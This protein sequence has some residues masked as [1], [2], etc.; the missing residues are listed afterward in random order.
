MEKKNIVVHKSL[1]Y[2]NEPYSVESMAVDEK[3][4]ILA[5]AR[6][7]EERKRESLLEFWNIIGKPI[8][9]LKTRKLG[10]GGVEALLWVNSYLI[11]SHLDGS[12]HLHQLH[13]TDN[14]RIQVCPSPLWSLAAVRDN[15]FCAGSDSGAIFFLSLSNGKITVEKT[16]NI[17]FGMR[18]LSLAA[19]AKIVAAGSI[20]ALC[21]IG[22]EKSRI[23]QTFQLPRSE[24]RKPTIVWCLGILSD[25]ILVSGDSR[26]CVSFWN[27]ENGTIF[28][29]IESH[30]AD[31]LSL[32]I[33]NNWVYAAGVD[34]TI[35]RICSDQ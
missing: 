17:G 11:S 24:Q 35:V 26:G 7:S 28:Q 29:T 8:F 12:V 21:L 2:E 25:E 1:L 33:G 9:H 13:H 27:M 14:V 31:V 6:F 15:I 34:P 10:S 19:N 22:V 16:V 32:C 18:V 30:Q 20:D 4:G 3:Q 23:L 5:L